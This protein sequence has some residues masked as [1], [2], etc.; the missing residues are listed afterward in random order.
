M[1]KIEQVVQSKYQKELKM[2]KEM[3]FSLELEGFKYDVYDCGNVQLLINGHGIAKDDLYFSIEINENYYALEASFMKTHDDEDLEEGCWEEHFTLEKLKRKQPKTIIS[4]MQRI[5]NDF[6][7]LVA[8]YYA[9]REIWKQER[10]ENEQ[11]YKEKI[12]QEV[13]V[14]MENEKNQTKTRKKRKTTKV[15]ETMPIPVLTEQEAIELYG[16][17][18]DF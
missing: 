13:I 14:E 11:R 2:L 16:D 3:A 7:T 10:E 1:K 4:N 8:N 17:A 12:R 6:P 18:P 15:Q 5:I 9:Q